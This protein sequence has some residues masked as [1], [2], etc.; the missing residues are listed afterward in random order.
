MA[1]EDIRIVFSGSVRVEN[2]RGYLGERNMKRSNR[3]ISA[4]TVGARTEER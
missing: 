1:S 3:A 4:V 2:K